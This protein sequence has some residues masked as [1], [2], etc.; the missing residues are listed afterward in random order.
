MAIDSGP[1]REFDFEEWLNDGIKGLRGKV[2]SK[3]KR[4]DPSNF[5]AH[6]RNAQKEQLLALRSL[7]DSGIEFLEKEEAANQKEDVP[8]VL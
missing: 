7:L 3:T 8:P 2:Q 4:F 1:V 5:R 6:M